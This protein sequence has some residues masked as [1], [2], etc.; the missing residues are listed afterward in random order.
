MPLSVEQLDACQDMLQ[1]GREA[2]GLEMG[3]VSHIKDDLYTIV[4]VDSDGGVFVAGETF[5][6]KDTLC[7]EVVG[8]GK[9]MSI[10]SYKDSLGLKEH[11][12]YQSLKLEAYIGAPIVVN[13][14][15]WGTINFTS[16]KLRPAG[17]SENEMEYVLD[18]AHS[19]GTMLI[20]N[21]PA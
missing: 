1:L 2:I 8:T 14:A 11:P 16:L 18:C 4:A 7:R 6:L 9:S 10:S 21:A 12:L 20:D 13:G 19:I 3:I 17:F 5:Q 15:I